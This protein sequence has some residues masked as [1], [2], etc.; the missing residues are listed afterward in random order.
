MYRLNQEGRD[1]WVGGALAV[2]Y[3]K[4][5][6]RQA[7]PSTAD[8]GTAELRSNPCGS[9]VAPAWQLRLSLLPRKCETENWDLSPPPLPAAVWLRR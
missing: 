7:L 1:W 5:G 9:Q 6:T 8:M 4:L 2:R 3:R